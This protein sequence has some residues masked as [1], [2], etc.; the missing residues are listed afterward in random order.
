M[1][2]CFS[3][4]VMVAAL[5][6]AEP[7]QLTPQEK[8]AGWQLLFDGKSLKGWEDVRKST[9]PGDAWTIEAG[10]IKSVASPKLREDLFSVAKFGDFELTFEWKISKGGN[11]GVKY[12]VQDRFWLD[13]SRIKEYKKFEDLANDSVRSRKVTRKDGTQEYIVGFEYQVI[14]NGGHRDAQRGAYYQAG[15]LYGMVPAAKAAAKAVGEFNVARL[16]VKGKHFEHW[17]NGEKVAEGELDGAAGLAKTADRWTKESL[18]YQALANQPVKQCP[19]TLQNH[20][21]EAWFRNIK[22][23]PLK[24]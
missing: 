10:C 14:D 3:L 22:I 17:L 6:A 5:S 13:E 9:P 2:T 23:R 24:N 8:A 4:L 16:V 21:D 11:S 20:G 1:R 15:A 7:N 18:I 12:R 19:I